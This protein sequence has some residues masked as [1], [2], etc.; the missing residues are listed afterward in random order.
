MLLSYFDLIPS[1]FIE[2]DYSTYVLMGL[3]FCVGIT[4]GADSRIFKAIREFGFKIM[5]IPLATIIGTLIGVTLASLI[6]KQYSVWECMAVGSGFGYY[7]LSSIFITEYKGAELGTVALISNIIR[8][9][10]TLLFA[11]IIVV[12]FGKLA[13]ICAG[14]ATTADTTLPIISKVSGNEFIIVAIVHGI[15]VDLTVPFLVPFF[16]NI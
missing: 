2:N 13:P 9:I 11:P 15:T 10:I 16:C 14:G 6:V 3:M 7:S 1:F 4:I 8:E 5:I 12:L